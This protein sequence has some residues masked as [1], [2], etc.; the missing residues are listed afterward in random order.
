MTL[1]IIQLLTAR[2]YSDRNWVTKTSKLP[3]NK[4]SGSDNWLRQSKSTFNLDNKQLRLIDYDGNEYTA[5]QQ[6]PLNQP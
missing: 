5:P 2:L 3:E 1:D 4:S 6:S